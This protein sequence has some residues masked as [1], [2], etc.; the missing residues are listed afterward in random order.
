ML[1][2]GKMR[3][4]K[5]KYVF[6]HL[7]MKDTL[8]DKGTPLYSKIVYSGSVGADDKTYYTFKKALITHIIN[9]THS[10]LMK[11]LNEL[12]RF[13]LKYYANYKYII[14][15]ITVPNETM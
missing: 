10:K 12:I 3:S 4:G 14:N 9:V 6:K 15:D 1:L 5:T 2:V 7:L 11:F 13:K 8:G